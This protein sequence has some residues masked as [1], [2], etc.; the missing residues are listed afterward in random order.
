[1][2]DEKLEKMDYFE[3]IEGSNIQFIILYILLQVCVLMQ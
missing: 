1:M 2:R 3:Q